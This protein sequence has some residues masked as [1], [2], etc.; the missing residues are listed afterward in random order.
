MAQG[1]RQR[2][3]NAVRGQMVVWTIRSRSRSPYLAVHLDTTTLVLSVHKTVYKWAAAVLRYLAHDARRGGLFPLA[4]DRAAAFGRRI[5][6]RFQNSIPGTRK[7]SGKAVRN[8]R[9]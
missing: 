4:R 1:S 9:L 6:A 8:L 7:T 3:Q 2:A 5:A